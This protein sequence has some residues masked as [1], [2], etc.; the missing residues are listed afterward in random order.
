MQLYMASGVGMAKVM[1]SE[2]DE[3]DSRYE[4]GESN[5]VVEWAQRLG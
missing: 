1:G 5:D 4:S 3:C 2:A